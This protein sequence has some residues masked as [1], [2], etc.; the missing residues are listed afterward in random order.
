MWKGQSLQKLD[1][2]V[3]RE[4]HSTVRGFDRQTVA[5]KDVPAIA[6]KGVNDLIA[7]LTRQCAEPR[8][9]VA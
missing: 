2:L 8:L 3:D 6:S 1:C 5:V 7:F 9:L 4:R